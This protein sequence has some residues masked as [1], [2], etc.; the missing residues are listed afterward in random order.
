MISTSLS[1]LC[2]FNIR[3]N[4]CLYIIGVTLKI[5]ELIQIMNIKF[6]LII[7]IFNWKSTRTNSF[8]IWDKMNMKSRSVA[9][10][11]RVECHN[12]ASLIVSTY[13]PYSYLYVYIFRCRVLWIMLESDW[14]ECEMYITGKCCFVVDKWG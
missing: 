3:L 13:L 8:K 10:S 9:L 5:I 6:S 12:V 4:N 7:H 11:D 14:F 1:I 2:I